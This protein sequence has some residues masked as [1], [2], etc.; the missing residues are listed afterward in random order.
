MRKSK[1]YKKYHAS[2]F[3]QIIKMV[4]NNYLDNALVKYQEY[5]KKYPDDYLAYSWYLILLLKLN[6]LSEVSDGLKKVDFDLIDDHLTRETYILVQI[7]L[8]IHLLDFQKAY[9]ILMDNKQVFI[10]RDWSFSCTELFLRKQ[11]GILTE[12]DYQRNGYL[13]SQ[14]IEYSEERFFEHISKHQYFD[15]NDNV[16]QFEENFPLM[17]FYNKIKELISTANKI[18]KG[19]LSQSYLFKYDCNG[20]VNGK[21]VDYIEVITLHETN[22]IITMYPYRNKENRDSIDLTPIIEELP[23]VKRISQIDKFNQRYSKNS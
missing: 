8:Y 9:D 16:C 1:K 13:V 4:D 22:E 3:N 12:N 20:R 21:M 23:K 17:D 6:K 5:F 11:L 7:E 19:C 14:I 18:N 2:E 15:C 10:D